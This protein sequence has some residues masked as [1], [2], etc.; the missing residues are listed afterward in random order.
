MILPKPGYFLWNPNR[1]S[2]R[3]GRKLDW[4]PK[5][6]LSVRCTSGYNRAC[7]S[8]APTILRNGSSVS[9]KCEPNKKW[10]GQR[11]RAVITML[12][13]S[14]RRRF[15]NTSQRC[16]SWELTIFVLHIKCTQYPIFDLHCFIHLDLFVIICAA[17]SLITCT[18]ICQIDFVFTYFQ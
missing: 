4:V 8:S 17:M 10:L 1:V 14:I 2:D 6:L 16:L 9:G 13:L 7:K 11:N 15:L 12:S 18:R 3:I 5:A